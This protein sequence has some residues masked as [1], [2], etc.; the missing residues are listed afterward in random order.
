MGAL[1]LTLYQATQ[2]GHCVIQHH[3]KHGPNQYPH[4]TMGPRYQQEQPELRHSG[5]DVQAEPTLPYTRHPLH[6]WLWPLTCGD[7]NLNLVK[8]KV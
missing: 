4:P 3:S 5:A 8:D 7:I 1:L 2:C 6:Y